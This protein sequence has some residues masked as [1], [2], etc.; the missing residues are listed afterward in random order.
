MILLPPGKPNARAT[1]LLPE[2]NMPGMNTGELKVRANS[3]AK[4]ESGAAKRDTALHTTWQVH[5]I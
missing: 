4:T 5:A 2:L 1:G 3:A